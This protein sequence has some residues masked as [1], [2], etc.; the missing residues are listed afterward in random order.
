MDNG[1]VKNP[2]KIVK[3]RLGQ[4]LNF[5]Y[6]GDTEEQIKNRRLER[7]DMLR[8]LKE[9]KKINDQINSEKNDNTCLLDRIFELNGELE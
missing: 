9:L 5:N 1:L 7:L 8:N 3:M 2:D 6:E 4:D